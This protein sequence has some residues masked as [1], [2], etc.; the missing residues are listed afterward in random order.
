MNTNVKNLLWVV[1]L[2]VA[3]VG[4]IALPLTAAWSTT[5]TCSPINNWNPDAGNGLVKCGTGYSVVNVESE[6]TQPVYFFHRGSLDAG[7]LVPKASITT[8]G[9]KRCVGCNNGSTYQA[10][11]TGAQG[12]LFCVSGTGTNDAGT[13]LA[14]EC[15]R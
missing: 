2:S 6:S 1:A 4:A 12:S 7:N 14:V 13:V 10:E 9:L 5:V 15:G 8:V 3:A 11:V